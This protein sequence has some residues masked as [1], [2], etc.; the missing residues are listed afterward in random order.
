MVYKAHKD[1]I[2]FENVLRGLRECVSLMKFM[3]YTVCM[4]TCI[5]CS[6]KGLQVKILK[7]VT[8]YHGR[9]QDSMRC[10]TIEISDVYTLNTFQRHVLMSCLS[11]SVTFEE[12][13]LLL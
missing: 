12:E 6:W 2:M 5:H 3:Q 11:Y 9:P 4:Y 1:Y 7:S 10:I 8:L 13:F